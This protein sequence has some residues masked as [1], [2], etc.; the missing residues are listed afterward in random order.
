MEECRLSGDLGQDS[1]AETASGARSNFESIRND[2][3][4]DGLYRKTELPPCLETAR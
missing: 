1:A 3:V 4:A 2:N